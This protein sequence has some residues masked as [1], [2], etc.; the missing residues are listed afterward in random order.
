MKNKIIDATIELSNEIGIHRITTNHVIDRLGISPGT[1]YYH[2]KNKEEIIRKIFE[3]ITSEFDALFTGDLSSYGIGKYAE[4]IHRIYLLY[5][6]YRSFYYDVSMLL[7]RDEE[8]EKR[9]RENYRLKNEKLRSLTF[10][11]EEKGI[12]KKFNSA[13]ERDC[14][15]ENLW[16]IS[17]YRL[18]FLR[19]A[20]ETDIEAL[21]EKGVRS[22]FM[23][24]KPYFTAGSSAEMQKILNI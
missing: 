5:Y 2:F 10:M 8:L 13:V 9:Y 20:G 16:I 6:K 17:D 1:F 12:L 14:Y 19:A 18:S 23:F 7:D 21:I 4:I 24:M 3:R 11:L 15:L 22:Y